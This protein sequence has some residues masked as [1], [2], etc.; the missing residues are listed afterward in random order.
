M[1]GTI[2]F[3]IVFLAIGLTVVMAAMRSGRKPRSAPESRGTRRAWGIGIAVL[4]LVVGLGLPILVYVGNRDNSVQDGPAGVN[5]TSAEAS[6]RLIFAKR[7]ATCHTL[8]GSNAVGRV[9]PNLDTLNGGT[10]LKASFVLNAI[11]QGRARGA[12]QMPANVVVGTEAQDV[13]AYVARVAG[14]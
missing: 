14:R 3:V 10:G 13:A 6:G 12:G 1:I 11:Q 5:L 2:V 7:C 9:G 4:I 8:S